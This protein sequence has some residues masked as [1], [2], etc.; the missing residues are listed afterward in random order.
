MLLGSFQS[1]SITA[2]RASSES[3]PNTHSVT[4]LRASSESEPNTHSS[5]ASFEIR[6]PSMLTTVIGQSNW[7]S[8]VLS[9]MVSSTVLS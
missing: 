9:L 2:L 6:T 4:P 3:E 5:G 8:D 1:H 7:I